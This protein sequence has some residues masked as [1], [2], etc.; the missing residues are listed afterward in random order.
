MLSL[1]KK[2]GKIITGEDSCEKAIQKGLANIVFVATDASG[3]TKK[4]FNNKTT[5]YKVPIYSLFTKEEMGNAIGMHNRATLV[6]ADA[7]FAKRILELLNI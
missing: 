3:N 5:Y 1:A 4:K 2:A 7:G 6:V